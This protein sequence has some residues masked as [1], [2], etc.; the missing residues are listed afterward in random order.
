MAAFVRAAAAAAATWQLVSGL[1]V[2]YMGSGGCDDADSSC[3]NDPAAQKVL[4]AVSVD[5]HGGMVAL[6]DLALSQ[7]GIP[8]WLTPHSGCLFVTR[9]DK[10]DVIAY[11]IGAGDKLVAPG[12]SSWSGGHNPVHATV[13]IDG[14]FLVVANY[15]GPDGA[16]KNTGAS[17]ASLRI[18]DDC[19]LTV[20]DFKNHT[21]HSV[22]P[23][24]QGAAHVHSAYALSNGL[25]YVCDLGLDFVFTYKLADDGKLQELHRAQ[26]APGLGPRHI[27]QHP[28]LPVMYVVT[29]MGE[30]VLT[31]K[32][33]VDGSLTLLQTSTV[34]AQG[35]PGAGSKAA[36]LAILPDGSMLYA[37]NRGL[38]NTVSAFSVC[39]HTGELELAQQ[40]EAPAYPR[41]M[42]LAAGVSV[43]L[44]G[45]QSKTE[46]WTYTVGSDGRLTKAN[47]LT[48]EDGVTAN[49]AA[50]AVLAAD[51]NGPLQV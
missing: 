8:A 51:A 35:R 15:D 23:D 42:A 36:E 21:G 30:V 1:D 13:S 46:L 39:S 33:E 38:E 31:Y 41:G 43:L 49:V 50:F 28:K 17:V 4:R 19:G 22:N 5:V 48:K 44:V 47:V 26:T 10:D 24:R 25:I 32:M 34:L 20:A 27:V 3:H 12:V 11:K 7:D 29:E 45:G 2:V 37:T 9:P 16:T 18:G 6:P 14:R 40:V